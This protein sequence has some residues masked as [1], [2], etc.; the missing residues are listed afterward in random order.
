MRLRCRGECDLDRDRERDPE[1]DLDLDRDPE[2]EERVLCDPLPE[3]AR[4][5]LLPRAADRDT[6]WKGAMAAS[7]MLV[8]I[9]QP[10]TFSISARCSSSWC[11]LN[12]SSP[13]Y[14]SANI[15]PTDHKSD[16]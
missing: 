12:K 8:G 7:V 5:L 4:R 13:V 10:K 2:R 1:R 6:D 16:G 11:V 3:R 9:R 14:S 15:Q